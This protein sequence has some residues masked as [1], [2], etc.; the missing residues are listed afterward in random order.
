MNANAVA[1]RASRIPTAATAA[2]RGAR[3]GAGRTGGGGDGTVPARSVPRKERSTDVAVI[4][5]P[6]AGHAPTDRAQQR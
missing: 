1:P 6:H 4:A 2:V 3:F 5:T